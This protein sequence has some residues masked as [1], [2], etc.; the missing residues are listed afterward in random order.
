[1]GTGDSSGCIGEPPVSMGLAVCNLET[2][3]W[4]DDYVALDNATYEQVIDSTAEPIIDVDPLTGELVIDVPEQEPVIEIDP[5]TGEL[6]VEEPEP[7]TVI[8]VDPL[9]GDLTL[10]EVDSE[11]EAVEEA[12][13]EALGIESDP[14]EE[15]L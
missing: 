5:L 12:I 13:E 10:E 2:G 6:T 11:E 1:M 14:V 9:T 4:E 15:L 3:L 8:E 7:E